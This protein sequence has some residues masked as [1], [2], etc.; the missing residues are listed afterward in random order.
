LN[1][2]R[3]FIKF[4][5]TNMERRTFLHS[6]CA[7]PF[8]VMV[9]DLHFLHQWIDDMPVTERQPVLFTGHGSPMNAI[10]TNPYTMALQRMG[11]NILSTNRPKAVLIVSAHWLTRGTFVQAGAKPEIIY[12]FGGFPDQL[13]KVQYPASGAPDLAKEAAAMLG[14][15][16]VTTDWGLDHGAWAVLKH[17]FPK[18]DIPCFQLSI[19]WGKPMQHHFELAGMLSKLRDSG[20]LIIGS[21]NIVH[22]LGA[23]IPMLG[24][25]DKQPFDWAIE[26]DTWVANALNE[27]DFRK[28]IEYENAG[29]MGLMAVPSPDHYIPMLYSLGLAR[30]GESV[31]YFYESVEY[32]GISMR[33][34][35]VQ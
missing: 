6:L 7:L 18:A 34:F 22:N 28:L 16:E 17:L 2:S 5:L 26:F 10:E 8:G 20:V 33:S 15:A 29:N 30:K 19:D 27:G 25:G 21:G 3:L 35:V 12:D 23:S 1:L 11:E 32:G 13:Y 31:S 24:R 4:V 9:T 14:K